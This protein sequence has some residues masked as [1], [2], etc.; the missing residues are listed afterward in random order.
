MPCDSV[1]CGVWLCDGD[2]GDSGDS[3]GSGENSV[4][5]VTWCGCASC[6]YV[7]LVDVE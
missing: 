5:S 4:P 1:A 3:G 6:D 2:S 7:R